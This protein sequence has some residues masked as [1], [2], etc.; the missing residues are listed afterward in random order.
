[1]ISYQKCFAAM[2]CPG[3]NDLDFILRVYPLNC[4]RPR[5]D[6]VTKACIVRYAYFS[7]SKIYTYFV[8]KASCSYWSLHIE[9]PKIQLK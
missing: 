8:Q 4:Q 9:Q 3:E 1:M 7:C 5:A 6:S 2:N